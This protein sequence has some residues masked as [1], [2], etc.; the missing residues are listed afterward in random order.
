MGQL[1]RHVLLEAQCRTRDEIATRNHAQAHAAAYALAE[2]AP[3]ASAA[4]PLKIPAALWAGPVS[5][6][7]VAGVFDAG[8]GLALASTL[9]ATLFLSV[10]ALRLAGVLLPAGHSP[11]RTVPIRELPSMTVIVALHNEAS[12]VA[13]LLDHLS[14]IDY[15]RDRLDVALAIEADDWETLQAA[16]LAAGSVRTRLPVCVMAVPPIGPRT[17]P[18]ALNFALQRTTGALVA[19]YDAEDAP[20]PGQLRAAAETFAADRSLGCVQAP[21]GWY[22]RSENW[23]TRMFALEYAAQFHVILPLFLRLGWPLPLGGTSN[24]F[25]RQF[26]NFSNKF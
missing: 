2:T 15:P 22:N 23:L 24:F 17:K 18:K 4:Y 13:G 16:H 6:L 5:F 8:A 3:E 14:R 9:I 25:T 19:V 11:R 21:L 12:V 26:S 10:A 20:T 1:F 7:A